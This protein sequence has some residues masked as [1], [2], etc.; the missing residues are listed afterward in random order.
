MIA[1]FTPKARA[2]VYVAQIARWQELLPVLRGPRLL[3][4]MQLAEESRCRPRRAV[5]AALRQAF[6][7][8]A[9]LAD[10]RSYRHLTARNPLP[11]ALSEF[12]YEGGRPSRT[13]F[14]YRKCA[15]DWMRHYRR[16]DLLTPEKCLE[17]AKDYL[18]LYRK[19]VGAWNAKFGTSA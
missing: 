14:F 11:L 12:E 4:E 17:L 15:L 1:G 16:R 10:A 7:G 18:S 6:T 13:P 8:A 3:E 9:R 19:S 5:V 2:A